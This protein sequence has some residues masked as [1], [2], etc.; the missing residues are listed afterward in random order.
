MTS[1]Y[2]RM[3]ITSSVLPSEQASDIAR[4]V[5]TIINTIPG[6]DPLRPNFGSDAYKYID[7]PIAS[8]AP[9]LTYSIRRALEKWEP[10][11]EVQK[12]YIEMGEIGKYQLVIESKTI[13]LKAYL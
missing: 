3:N 11:I 1:Q 8:V 4:C 2:Q 10:R 9:A 6:S 13:T 12:C 5:T 7:H